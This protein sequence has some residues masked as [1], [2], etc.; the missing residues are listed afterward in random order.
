MAVF[1][2]QV[3]MYPAVGVPGAFASVNPVV[4]TPK[5]YIAS[6]DIPVGG[7]C[8]TDPAN[9]GCAVASSG[10]L[11]LGFVARDVV[12]P[13]YDLNA[14]DPNVA[15][16]GSNVNV[17]KKG[18]FYVTAPADVAAGDPV[19]ADNATGAVSASDSESTATG[20]V[21]TEAA[22]EGDI[23]V[24]SNWGVAAASSGSGDDEGGDAGGDAGGDGGDT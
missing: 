3:N 17:M 12:Y 15:P 9:E 13:L 19:Y 2:K 20:F 6:K 8:W 4:S 18:D 22:K 23:T 5:S 11:F 14:A 1:A 7:F 16:A 21:F 24:I 10:G